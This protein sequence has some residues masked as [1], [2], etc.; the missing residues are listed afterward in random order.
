MLTKHLKD[1]GHKGDGGA[2]DAALTLQVRRLTQELHNL[3]SSSRTVTVVQIGSGSGTSITSFI[4]PAAVVGGVSYA[5][6]WWKGCSFSDIMYVT[7]KGMNNAV[8]GVGKQL[9]HV[10]AA[11]ASTRKHMN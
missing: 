6:M 8:A 3:A 10:S 11:L 9:E 5:Y 4:L 7:R 1:D 2:N